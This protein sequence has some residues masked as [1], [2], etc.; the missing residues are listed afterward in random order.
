MI[1]VMELQVNGLRALNYIH[2]PHDNVVS[3]LEVIIGRVQEC[4]YTEMFLR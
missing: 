4:G 3:T 2:R 1:L